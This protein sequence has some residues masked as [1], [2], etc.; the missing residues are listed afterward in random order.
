VEYCY[1]AIGERGD[2]G[3]IVLPAQWANLS[4]LCLPDG[5]HNVDSGEQS[6]LFSFVYEIVRVQISSPLYCHQWKTRENPYT[7]SPATSAYTYVVV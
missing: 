2:D 7:E 1:P 5:V 3:E 6:A 4:S